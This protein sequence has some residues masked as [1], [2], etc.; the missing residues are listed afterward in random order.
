VD[1]SPSYAVTKVRW[2]LFTSGFFVVAAILVF[3]LWSPFLGAIMMIGAVM[4]L[5]LA[6][7]PMVLEQVARWLTLGFRR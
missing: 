2:A 1:T 4:G 7:G 6:V 5:L 3:W